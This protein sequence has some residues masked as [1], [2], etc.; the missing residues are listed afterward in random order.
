MPADDRTTRTRIWFDTEFIEDGRTID[1]ISIGMVRE[2]GQTFY[3]ENA[4]CDF[5]KASPWVMQNVVPHLAGP[6]LSKF[7]IA[8]HA[9]EFAGPN[10]EFWAYYADYDWVALCQLFGTM[11]QLPKGWPMFCLDLKQ[12][13]YLAG[14][15]SLPE[16]VGVEHNALADALWTKSAWEWLQHGR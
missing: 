5:G 11:M 8:R 3:A 9:V 14:D 2:D 7:W 4:D 12:S 13:V 15:P 16:Q 10:P 6:Q 1:L